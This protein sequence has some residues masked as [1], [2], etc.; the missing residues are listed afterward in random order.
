MKITRESKKNEKP[1]LTREFYSLIFRCADQPPIHGPGIYDNYILGKVLKDKTMYPH[2]VIERWNK[3]AIG[4]FLK[5]QMKERENSNKF[6]IDE[7]IKQA[8]YFNNDTDK[9]YKEEYRK[10]KEQRKKNEENAKFVK[11]QIDDSERPIEFNF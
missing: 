11:R 3:Q 2:N 8:R 7:E 5:K 1:L 6:Y 9:Y 4:Q 10:S